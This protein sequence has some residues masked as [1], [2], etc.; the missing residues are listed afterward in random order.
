[1]KRY[2][3][4]FQTKIIFD[5]PITEQHFLLKSLPGSYPFQHIYDE[6]LQSNFGVKLFEDRDSFGNRTLAGSIL[7]EHREL[8]FAVSGKVLQGK[9]GIREPLD[10][11][12]LYETPYTRLSDD[13][14]SLADCIPGENVPQLAR[15]ICS[16]V[17]DSLIYLPES[18][19]EK[20]TA[21]RSFEQRT[22]VC[23]DYAQ[24]ML[25]LLRRRTIPARYCTGLIQGEGKTHAWVEY[26]H[27]GAWLGLDP[28]HN[29][30][31]EY[32]Y[33]KISHGRDWSDCRVNHGCFTSFSGE[34]KQTLLI[35]AKVG[36]LIA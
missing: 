22:G 5:Q 17:H 18:T 9:Y 29:Q 11:I 2:N 27:D 4:R 30:A 25:A 8:Y 31:L 14:K 32:G 7:A 6:V 34:V 15:N 36:E 21:A 10:R 28:T 1:M 3:F 26:Y 13:L 24:I 16:A 35:E 19:N 20:W 33:L 12:F 23:Q